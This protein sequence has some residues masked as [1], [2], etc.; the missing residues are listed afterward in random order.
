MII[1][2]KK[3][4]MVGGNKAL[5]GPVP[6]ATEEREYDFMRNELRKILIDVSSRIATLELEIKRAEKEIEEDPHNYDIEKWKYLRFISRVK[7]EVVCI[8]NRLDEM[9]LV[10]T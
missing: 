3:N 8:R 5:G 6:L 7:Y 2:A 4:E 1:M 10:L 9:D